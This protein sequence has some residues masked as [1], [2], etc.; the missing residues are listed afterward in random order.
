MINISFYL[1]VLLN[2]VETTVIW[3]ESSDLLSILDKL[4]PDTLSDSRVRLLGLH[5]D[6]LEN[7]SLHTLTC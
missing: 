5:T 1:I 3:D 4:Y 7:D 2:K 6:L